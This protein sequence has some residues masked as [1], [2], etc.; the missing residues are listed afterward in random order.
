MGA[1]ASVRA[2]LLLLLLAPAVDAQDGGIEVFA[3]ETLFASG[4][5]VSL[6]HIYESKGSLRR[7]TGGA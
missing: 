2:S 6:T 3:A 1:L 5:R 7:G 4:T